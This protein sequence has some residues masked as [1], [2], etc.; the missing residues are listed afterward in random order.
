MN[1]T[2]WLNQ[3]IIS[4]MWSQVLSFAKGDNDRYMDEDFLIAS[5]SIGYFWTWH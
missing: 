5:D 4:V 1:Y 3:L 2:A